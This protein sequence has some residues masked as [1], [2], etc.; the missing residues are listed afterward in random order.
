[1]TSLLFNRVQKCLLT[2]CIGAGLL[3]SSCNDDEVPS[4]TEV[5]VP[6]TYDFEREGSSTVSYTGQTSRLNQLGEIKAY[7]LTADAG[8]A[9]GAQALKDMYENTGGNGGGNFSTSY[10]TQLKDK[11]SEFDRVYFEDLMEKTATASLAG[12]ANTTASEGQAGLLTRGNGNTI[13]VD[14][15]GHEFTQF[16]EKGLMGAVFYYQICEVYLTDARVGDE[17]N[18]DVIVDG[19]NY[20]A[21]EH[22]WDEA[23]GYLGVPTDFLSNT[24]GVRFWGSY[25]NGRNLLLGSNATLMNA[26]LTGRTAIVNKN[27]NIRDAQRNIIYDELE[28]VV[29]ATA[30]HY[31]NSSL[32]A[33]NDGD[34]MHLLSEAY[35]FIQD[36]KYNSRAQITDAQINTIL[37]THIG[38][39]FWQVSVTGLN[40][41]KNL[42]S[43]IY[44]LDSVKDDL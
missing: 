41:A 2:A 3:L 28:K 34:R 18:N 27:S 20:T 33:T 29:A 4:V 36:L 40:E 17:V 8:S 19:T 31:I 30:V 24:D 15:N 37:G 23:F 38:T 13:L 42:L 7:L 14:E 25:I 1:M 11:T 12:A 43:S 32:A 6:S 9:V 10:S 5:S 44:G 39:N 35:I 22:H 16:I 21:M 26:F